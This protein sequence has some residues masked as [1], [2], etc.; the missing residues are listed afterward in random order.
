MQSHSKADPGFDTSG[1]TSMAGYS[2]I[3]SCSSGSHDTVPCI[4]A[5]SL[6]GSDVL[7]GKTANEER[8]IPTTNSPAI[9]QYPII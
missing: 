8:I 6:M 5:V 4:S 2:T 9:R 7:C 3:N 1:C